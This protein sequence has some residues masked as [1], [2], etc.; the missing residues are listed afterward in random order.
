MEIYSEKFDRS[1]FRILAMQARWARL[2]NRGI[3][4]GKYCSIGVRSLDIKKQMPRSSLFQSMIKAIEEHSNSILIE[5]LKSHHDFYD[6][7]QLYNSFTRKWSINYLLYY[8]AVAND[9]LKAIQVLF[10]SGIL[11]PF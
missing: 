10:H 4:D 7:C 5:I 2:L 1:N 9:N 3:L 11:H 6:I 8:F